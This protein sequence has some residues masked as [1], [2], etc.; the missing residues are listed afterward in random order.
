MVAMLERAAE[1]LIAAVDLID[2]QS[3]RL[4]ETAVETARDA[5]RAAAIAGGLALGMLAAVLIGT[6]AL[7]V[8]GAWALAWVTNVPIAIAA[9]GGACL[10]VGLI[11][12]GA[13]NASAS[14]HDAKSSE[15]SATQ[16]THDGRRDHVQDTRISHAPGAGPEPRRNGDIPPHPDP[17][18]TPHATRD[19]RANA[20]ANGRRA[21]GGTAAPARDG[22]R[23][24]GQAPGSQ[25]TTQAGG[26][27]GTQAHG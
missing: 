19:P 15:S 12:L 27:T 4:K 20:R 25:P 21:F 8:A 22:H 17:H 11:G 3:H 18:P 9:A 6:L 2:A 10:V 26:T 1:S 24:Q 5:A 16:P 23:G 7:V 13:L 14:K